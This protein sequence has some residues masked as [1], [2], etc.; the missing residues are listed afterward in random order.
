MVK[1]EDIPALSKGHLHKEFIQSKYC[2]MINKSKSF[3]FWPIW[4]VVIL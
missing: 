2:E 4:L 3:M 1:I